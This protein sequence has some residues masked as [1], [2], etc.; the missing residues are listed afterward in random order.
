V[1]KNKKCPCSMFC[2][3]K[4][5]II[6]DYKDGFEGFRTARICLERVKVFIDTATAKSKDE[7]KKI[8]GA[9]APAAQEVPNGRK[10]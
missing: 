3:N 9:A 2:R 1:R 4:P 6:I 10:S 5:V 8:H 7:G